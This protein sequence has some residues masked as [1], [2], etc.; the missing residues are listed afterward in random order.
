MATDGSATS[1]WELFWEMI[2]GDFSVVFSSYE[3]DDDFA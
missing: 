2:L 3:Q 1:E